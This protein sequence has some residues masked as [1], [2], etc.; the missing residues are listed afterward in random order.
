MTGELV[1]R[2]LGKGSARK[3]EA[4]LLAQLAFQAS[5]IQCLCM[6]DNTKDI[7]EAVNFIK[8]RMATKDDVI[9]LRTELKSEIDSLRIEMQEGFASVRAEI[10][11]VRRRLE[12]L[13]EAAHNSAGLTKE[14]DHLMGRVRAIENHLG[15]QHK[16]A[17]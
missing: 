14:I 17:A 9:D 3:T 12:A 15:I 4:P 11:D 6:D 16:I 7:L 10:R 8:D 13:E 1:H 5:M 2:V